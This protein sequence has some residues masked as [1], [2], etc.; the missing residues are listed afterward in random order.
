MVTGALA[1]TSDGASLLIEVGAVL[2]VLA[3]LAR[4]AARTAF[5]PIPLYLLAGLAIGAVA[6]RDLDAAAV[7]IGTQIAVILLLFMLGLEYSIDDVVSSLQSGLFAGLVDAVLNFTPGLVAGLASG[8]GLA[9]LGGPRRRHLHLVVEHHRQGAGRPG[10]AG[11]QR[12][13]RACS[14]C[15]CSR[16]S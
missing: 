3:L 2:I 7:D 4:L 9:A 1:I 10:P 15:S 5:S 6:P 8:L 14:A 11:Q 12:D 16:T 13:A